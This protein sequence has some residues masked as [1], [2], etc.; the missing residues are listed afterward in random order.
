MDGGDTVARYIVAQLERNPRAKAAFSN[1]LQWT[2]N[3]KTPD[4]VRNTFK[5]TPIE[6]HF[7]LLQAL[8]KD[9][10]A[11]EEEQLG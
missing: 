8:E 6:I 1:T 7:A 4:W 3:M 11:M 10:A 2:Q 5:T 9:H